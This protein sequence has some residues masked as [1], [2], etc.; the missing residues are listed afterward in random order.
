MFFGRI[1]ASDV[2]SWL[3]G[4]DPDP[5]EDLRQKENGMTEYEMVG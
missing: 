2:N 1:D 3:T 5:G 4:E